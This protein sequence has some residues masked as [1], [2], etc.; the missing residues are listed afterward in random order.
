[1]VITRGSRWPR[2]TGVSLDCG[3]CTRTRPSGLNVVETM[4]KISSTSITSIIEIKLI[5]GSSRWRGRRFMSFGRYHPAL[6]Q[7]VD[8]FRGFLFHA[9][10]QPLDL[11]PQKPI[12]DQ[13]GNRD[14]ETGRGRDERFTDAAG[15]NPGIADAVGRDG[16][17]RVND[18]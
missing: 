8:E 10:H 16:V 12:G 3:N 9:H 1:M 4:K 5:S 14:R 15:Q 11:A 7:R 6:V 17:E 18:A 2:G 13:R